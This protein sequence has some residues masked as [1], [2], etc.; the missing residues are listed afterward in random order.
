MYY[1]AENMDN[2]LCKKNL[3]STG[4][5]K[6][7]NGHAYNSFYNERNRSWRVE[8]YTLGSSNNVDFEKW[9]WDDW[10]Y[11]VCMVERVKN[12]QDFLAFQLSIS[13]TCVTNIVSFFSTTEPN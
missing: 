1:S 8:C 13:I 12:R 2:S 5:C 10:K 6:Y 7:Y 3:Y 11:N 9:Y 4:L